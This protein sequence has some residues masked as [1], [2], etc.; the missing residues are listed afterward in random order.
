MRLDTKQMVIEISRLESEGK[1]KS[2][3]YVDVVHTAIE[4]ELKR[5]RKKHGVET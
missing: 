2:V 5:V 1:R 3:G 4:Y